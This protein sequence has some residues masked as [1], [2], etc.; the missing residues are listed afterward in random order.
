[1]MRLPDLYRLT[2]NPITFASEV[3]TEHDTSDRGETKETQIT[4][5]GPSGGSK[6]KQ[7]RSR[8]NFT[9]EQLNELERLFD[10]THYPDAFMREELS[11]RLGLSEARVQ[12]S[13]PTILECMP[14]SR[15]SLVIEAGSWRHG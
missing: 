5:T 2:L 15:V 4:C 11:Q 14:R 9:L 13:L 6:V 7:R 8:T 1:M 12:V 10:E 3:K